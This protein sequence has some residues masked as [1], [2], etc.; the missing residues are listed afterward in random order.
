MNLYFYAPEPSSE[1]FTQAY[2][3]VTA[4]L[5]RTGATV[6]TRESATGDALGGRTRQSPLERVRAIVIEGTKPDPEVGYLLAYAIAQKKPALLLTLKGHVRQSPLETFGKS[7]SIP[8]TLQ[9]ALYLPITAEKALLPFLERL[10]A[11]PFLQV[12]SIKFTLRITEDIEEYLH[13]KTHNTKISKA[14]YLR[15]AIQEDLISKDE[16]YKHYRKHRRSISGDG[17]SN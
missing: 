15:K 13:W 7:H 1:E 12:P 9:Q 2:R 8:K 3:A 17:P 16:A 11:I 5:E 6:W 10:D 14:D 4:V